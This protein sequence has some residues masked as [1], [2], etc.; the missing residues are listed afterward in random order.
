MRDNWELALHTSSCI[1]VP[2]RR[3]HVQQYHTWMQS[4]SLLEATASEPLS[5]EEEY[6]MQQSWRDDPKKCTFIIQGKRQDNSICMIGDTNLFFNDPE[7]P[8]S[9][10]IEIMIAEPDF[11]RKGIATAAL[12]SMMAYAHTHLG[13]ARFVAK[14]GYDNVS[15][16]AMFTS[17]ERLGYTV[18][19]KHDW[20]EETHCALDVRGKDDKGKKTRAMI[21]EWGLDTI[22]ITDTPPNDEIYTVPHTVWSTR[23]FQM[24][25]LSFLGSTKT[26][27]FTSTSTSKLNQEQVQ[28]GTINKVLYGIYSCYKRTEQYLSNETE[29]AQRFSKEHQHPVSLPEVSLSESENSDSDSDA[30]LNPNFTG[31]ALFDTDSCFFVDLAGGEL[32]FNGVPVYCINDTKGNT[33]KDDTGHI[34]WDGAIAFAKWLEKHS[35]IIKNKNIL[36]LGAGTGYAGLSTIPCGA[37]HVWLTDLDYALDIATTNVNKNVEMQSIVRE[38][39]DVR[40]L[41]WFDTEYNQFTDTEIKSIDVLIAADVI[42]QKVLVEPLS[43]TIVGLLQKMGTKGVA[44]VLYTSRY[45]EEFDTFVL[46]TI[47]AAGLNVEIQSH[48]EMDEVYRYDEAVVWKMTCRIDTKTK[49]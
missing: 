9:A 31:M 41:D 30:S 2:Y 21:Q 20:C 15:S 19:E 42:W 40:A 32:Q 24:K 46:D 49:K 47:Q 23:W 36:E 18:F 12:R 14:I 13:V 6:E 5:L 29:L 7:D 8:L 45:G 37:K 27:T 39:V 43:K 11:R 22:I 3:H 34:T 28:L 1:L 35:N 16:L 25:I 10:E 38:M 17:K 48:D 26:T 44:Y 4:T 33:D